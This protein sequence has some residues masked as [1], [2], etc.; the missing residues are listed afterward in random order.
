M[1]LKA[2]DVQEEVIAMHAQNSLDKAG[3]SVERP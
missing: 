3:G 1:S 2:K